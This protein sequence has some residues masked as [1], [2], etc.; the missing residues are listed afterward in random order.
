MS[1]LVVA[2]CAMH[3]N[4][5]SI[6]QTVGQYLLLRCRLLVQVQ[7]YDNNNIIV[8]DDGWHGMNS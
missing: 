3:N 2:A 7:M 6:E 1:L 8:M 4:I 5:D